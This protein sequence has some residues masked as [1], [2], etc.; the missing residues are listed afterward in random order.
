MPLLR[1][2][3]YRGRTE[4]QVADLLH[5]IHRAVVSAFNVPARD[6]YQVY[7]EHSLMNFVVEDTG[8]GIERSKNVVLISMTS[9]ARPEAQKRAFYARLTDELR[10]CG[11]EPNDIVVSIVTNTDADWSFGFGRAQFL[12]G[13]L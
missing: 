13:E 5:A 11:I 4:Q 2:D 8:L 10:P 3:T 7:Q 12:T 1:I 6:R 9:K